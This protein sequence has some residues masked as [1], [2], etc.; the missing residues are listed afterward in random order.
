MENIMNYI[1]EN[2]LILIPVLYVLGYIL[3]G[4]E[5][6]DDK[7]IPI[8]LLPVGIVLAMLIVGFD[9]NGFIQGVLITGAAVY[10]NQL[11]KQISK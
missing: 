11:V 7:Y 1:A 10:A 8:I 3:K 6:V 4:T 9:V 5:K 2:A